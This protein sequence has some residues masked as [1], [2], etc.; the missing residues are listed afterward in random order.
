MRRH[1]QRVEQLVFVTDEGENAPPRFSDAYEAYASELK[2]R[3]SVILVRIGQADNLLQRACNDLLRSWNLQRAP[4]SLATR[5]DVALERDA[6]RR[7]SQAMAIFV[8]RHHP[9][10]SGEDSGL[11]RRDG[12]ASLVR[13]D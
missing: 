5:H 7:Y 2:I 10:S 8:S 12:C 3:P 4:V 9:I 1:G 6:T 13:T 11:I